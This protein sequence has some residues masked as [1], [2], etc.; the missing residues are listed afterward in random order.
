MSMGY[1]NKD[2]YDLNREPHE[3]NFQSDF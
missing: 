3:F 2:V 1:I